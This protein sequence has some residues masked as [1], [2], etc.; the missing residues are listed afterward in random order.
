MG[1]WGNRTDIVIAENW[2]EGSYVGLT[3]RG[4]S[5][6]Y[7]KVVNNTFVGGS[8]PTL[9][10]GIFFAEVELKMEIRDDA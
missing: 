6:P 5:P 2:V 9:N 10:V 7:M 8:I 1:R 4:V 3:Y